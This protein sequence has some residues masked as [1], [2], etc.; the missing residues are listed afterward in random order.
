LVVG[1]IF[2][3]GISIFAIYSHKTLV[4]RQTII[5]HVTQGGMSLRKNT[6]EE[7]PSIFE[8][9]LRSVTAEAL[10]YANLD[11]LCRIASLHS[12]KISPLALR[13]FSLVSLAMTPDA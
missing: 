11:K 12:F 7:R 10:I 4:L 2:E 3:I 13:N 9:I 6:R 5:P 1:R 8:A